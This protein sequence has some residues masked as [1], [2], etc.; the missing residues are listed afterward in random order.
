MWCSATVT[1]AWCQSASCLPARRRWRWREGG[2][3]LWTVGLGTGRAWEG[4]KKQLPGACDGPGQISRHAH[5]SAQSGPKRAPPVGGCRQFVTQKLFLRIFL[6]KS[7]LGASSSCLEI[8]RGSDHNIGRSRLWEGHRAAGAHLAPPPSFF[9][10]AAIQFY[11]VQ[12]QM[13]GR[14]KSAPGRIFICIF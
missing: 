7:S 14:D 4:S 3:K 5:W 12:G 6:T 8:G 9:H 11:G 13:G 1:C 10:S 2:S